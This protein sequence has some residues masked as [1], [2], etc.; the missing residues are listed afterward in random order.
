MG[1][2][3]GVAVEFTSGA[4]V[5]TGEFI[6]GNAGIS[7]T[8]GVCVGG[9]VGVDVAAGVFVGGNVGTVVALGVFVGRTVGV[10]GG[11][12]V[13]SSVAAVVS[14]LLSA[15]WLEL[16]SHLESLSPAP[17]LVLSL[18]K[19]L[20]SQAAHPFPPVSVSESQQPP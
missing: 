11:D 8:A 12:K 3:E 14:A 9:N 1:S 7:V 6:G 18:E 2:A 19:P 15:T 16:P 5:T 17:V 10:V 13:G 4:S 20:A